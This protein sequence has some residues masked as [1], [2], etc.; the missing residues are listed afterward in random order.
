MHV[1]RTVCCLI[2][3][4]VIGLAQPPVRFDEFFEDAALR[5]DFYQT[6]E[7]N[8]EVITLDRLYREAV[9]PESRTWLLDP[10]NNG[11]YAVRAY[12]TTSNRLVYSRGFDTMFGE[13]RTTNPALQGVQRTF[14]RAVRIPFPKH[15]VKVEIDV[16][17][18]QNILRPRFSVIVDPQDFHIQKESGKSTD[19]IYRFQENG[20]PEHSVDIVFLAEGYTVEDTAKF[21][22]DVARISAA[23]FA[24]EPYKSRQSDFSL[25]GVLRP[26]VERGMDEPRLGSFKATP[27]NASFDTFDLDRYMLTEEGRA[28]R[29]MAAQV[30]YDAIVILVN[31]SRY[32]GGGIYNDYCITTVDHPASA[33][34]FVHE[35]GHSFAGLADEYY[36]ADVA[37]N[38][39]YPKGVEP[40]EPNITALLDP[41]RIKW[42]DQ[43][44]PGVA[45]P[46]EWGK[47]ALDSLQAERRSNGAARS[48]AL[49]EAAGNNVAEAGR[50]AI[51]SGFKA[52]DRALQKE[53]ENVRKKY[54]HLEET[55]GAFEGAGYTSRGMYRSM[56]YCLMIYHP[57]NEFC[58]VCRQAI[59]RM[60]DFQTTR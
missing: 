54:A 15:P 12:D 34:V 20:D 1:L 55:V 25:R 36:S 50:A 51:E 3:L 44:S 58:R 33:G 5:M 32:G 38:D 39:F 49:K 26:S 42:Q 4:S 17:D 28:L 30:P 37:Y 52:K 21:R 23:L 46:T 47:E 40:L 18:R 53:I 48:R 14:N 24:V 29:A 41:T 16:R 60:I 10:F 35:F 7:G 13:Y 22:S 11:R 6:G 19:R 43:L 9:W 8:T 56:I 2:F 45:L 57:K 31:S 59:N 27:L